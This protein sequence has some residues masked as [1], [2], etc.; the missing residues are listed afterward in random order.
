MCF[1]SLTNFK[2]WNG[3]HVSNLAEKLTKNLDA[4]VNERRD[5]RKPEVNRRA[6]AQ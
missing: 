4:I 5:S 2:T 1:L 6:H 3:V